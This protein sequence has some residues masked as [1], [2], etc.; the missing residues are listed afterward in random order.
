MKKLLLSV[1]AFVLVV[2]GVYAQDGEGI[3]YGDTVTGEITNRDYEVLYTFEGSAD[4]IV[5]AEMEALTFDSELSSPAILLLNSENDVVADTTETFSI[6]GA[7]LVAELPADDTYTLIATRADG[8]G[9][10]DQ[11][12]Y[13]LRLSEVPV[14]EAGSNV[15]AL[16]AT[17]DPANYVAVRQGDEPL[18]LTYEKTDGEFAPEIT[19]NRIEGSSLE[20]V[21]SLTGDELQEATVSLPNGAGLYVIAVTESLFSFSFEPEDAKYRLSI[22]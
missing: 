17:D 6:R 1:V 22:D 14:L 5:I 19:V 13:W 10:T 21:I 18:R 12:E 16:I 20:S 3:V 15:D 9:G 4:D 11:G 7:L 2:S 8:R